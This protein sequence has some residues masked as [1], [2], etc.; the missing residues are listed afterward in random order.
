[1]VNHLLGVLYSL[2]PVATR[3]FYPPEWIQMTDV[4]IIQETAGNAL[5]AGSREGEK[6]V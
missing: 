2:A 6:K 3:S 4:I 5:P 1:M